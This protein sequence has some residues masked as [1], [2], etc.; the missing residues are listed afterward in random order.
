MCG[1]YGIEEEELKKSRRG[2]INEPRDVTIYLI[3][4]LR[5]DTLEV[6]GKEFSLHRFSSV[7]SIIQKVKAR[8]KK[9]KLMYKKVEDIRNKIFKGQT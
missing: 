6:I 3:R 1:H 9:D 2:H 7:S 4:L 5:R 8:L